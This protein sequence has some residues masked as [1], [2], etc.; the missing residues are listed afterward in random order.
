M[1]NTSE[2]CA[3]P[4]CGRIVLCRAFPALLREPARGSEG[5]R[6]VN[7]RD[8]ACFYHADRKAASVCDNCG[9]FMCELCNVAIAGRH[10]CPRCTETARR[11]NDLSALSSE[12]IL[13]DDIALL[14]AILPLTAPFAVYYAIR[15]WKTSTSILPR[16]K[17]RFTA[18]F[19]IG[20]IQIVA[21]LAILALLLR[22]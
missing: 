17:I 22:R 3:C 13:R 16:T 6:I 15:Y 21:W 1:F 12:H 14:F 8:A 20:T 7:D 10:F 18:A 4:A 9:R 2:P 19:V 11:E 5:E